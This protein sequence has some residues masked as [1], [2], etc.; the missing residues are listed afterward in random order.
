MTGELR[1][2]RALA[3]GLTAWDQANQRYLVTHL[4]R[5]RQALA[6]Y[7][8]RSAH[9]T[10]A[11]DAAAT[12]ETEPVM[13]HRHPA[14]LDTV[15]ER[16]GLSSF[17]R[18]L[19]LL[20]AGIE[21]DADFLS[22]CAAAQGDAQCDY[23]TFAL[24]LAALPAAHWS[25]LTPD[26]PL[27]RWELIHVEAG[28]SLTR[29]PLRIDERI[30][31][32]L[33]GVNHMDAALAGVV[34]RVGD[35]GPLVPSQAAVAEEIAAT[36]MAAAGGS[37]FPVVHLCGSDRGARHAVAV[38]ACQRLGLSLFRSE[39]AWLPTTPGEVER[40]LRIW[41]R[42]SLLGNCVLLVEADSAESHDSS[43]DGVLTQLVEAH[44]GG[45]L[46]IG[47]RERRS[48]W[49]RPTIVFD[50]NKPTPDE[51]RSLWT[52]VIDQ[53]LMHGTAPLNGHVDRLV[54]T[55]VLDAPAIVAAVQGAQGRLVAGGEA[56]PSLQATADALWAHCRS[57]A[58]PQLDDLAQHIE[59]TA[60]W[61]DLVL[62]DREVEVLREI[63]VHVRQRSR[64]YETWGFASKG[65]RGL[66]VSAL[67]AGPSGTGKTM[68][69]EVLAQELNLDL[70]RIDLSAV[71]SKYIGETE[72]NLRRVFD[73]AETGGAILLFDEADA[74][75]GKRSEVK[76]S[77]DRYANI[78]VSYLLQRME[79]YRGLAILTT[80][81]R[82]ALDTAFLRRIRFI[83]NFPFPDAT[84][85]AQIWRRIFP[86]A[87]PVDG[88]DADKLAQLSV[89]GG[90]IRNIALYAAFLAA[91]A[92]AEGETPVGM[93]HILAAARREY[94]KMERN[95]TDAEVRGWVT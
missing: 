11:A 69:A 22:T 65:R 4:E 30:L 49:P 73:A 87:T 95:L 85:R 63:A 24:A 15:C 21:L 18:D 60:G 76:D 82:D 90:A 64:V 74:L 38:T 66:G 29:S 61:E 8:E 31:H 14:S 54:G 70:Y 20:C 25:A 17:E 44:A 50:V 53:T 45:P 1:E 3:D 28:R 43:R 81:L 47:S 57:Q 71:V 41:D 52:T 6:A 67:F 13:A 26:A 51:Q 56:Q 42:Q 2:K 23:P 77:H 46:L 32:Y 35:P 7:C 12:P 89:A 34:Q 16:F 68:A 94:A 79:S 72:K 55:F 78:E 75:F 10:A 48:G 36:W 91:D 37:A 33:A 62:P 40:L 83:V 59:T 80:N 5:V 9:R 39:V 84:Q 93:A 27:R 86:V 19:L 92:G 88:L 58:R